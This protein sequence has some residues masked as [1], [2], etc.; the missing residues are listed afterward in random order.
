MAWWWAVASIALV[1]LGTALGLAYILR[2]GNV[3]LVLTYHSLLPFSALTYALLG[4][5]VASRHPGNIIGWLFL[6]TA[7]LLS[8]TALSAGTTAIDSLPAGARLPWYEVVTWTNRW[9]W[10]PAGILPLVFVL[11]FFP[12]GRL[13]SRRWRWLAWATGLA[14]A[15]VVAGVS[16]HPGA[17]AS[18][19]I[20][21]P[22]PYGIPNSGP[23]LEA[24]LNASGA[25]LV[26]SIFGAVW[27]VVLRFRR[28][29]GVERQQIKWV[30]YI[31]A[32]LLAAFSL[33]WWVGP[34]LLSEAA[35]EELGIVMSNLLVLGVAISVS[36]AIL[37]HQLYDIDLVINRT[38]VYGALTAAVVAIYTLVVGGL[39]VAL[40]ARGNVALSW[41]GLALVALIAQPMRD[42]LQRGVN[43][44]M[45]GQ[46]DDPYAVL[47]RLGHQME[48]STAPRDLLSSL[49][50][51]IAETLKLPYVA[52]AVPR[53][54]SAP[55]S[56]SATY[57][58]Y[59]PIAV[60]L[61]L[62]YQS[63]CVGELL[64]A[65]RSSAEP[66]TP[67]EQ[68]L[69]ADIARQAGVVV[70]AAALSSALQQSR[71]H[72]VT[73]REEE[74]RRIRRDLHD[75][76]GPTLASHAYGLDAVLDLI[77]QDPAAAKRLVSDLKSQTQ[78]TLTD[79]RRLVY[80]LRP[81]ALDE[82][83]LVAALQ[84]LLSELGD[85]L[86][87]RVEASPAILPPLSAAVEVAAYRI[88]A[89]AVT[90]AAR[91]AHAQH[92]R[93]RLAASP[94]ELTVDVSDDGRGLPSGPRPGVGLASMR[95]RAAELGGTCT[96]QPNPPGG[97]RVLAHLPLHAPLAAA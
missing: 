58:R 74:R 45:F 68:R 71:E 12:D 61:P 60:R 4:A 67:A 27:A 72:L 83:G 75:G 49:A 62:S 73:T 84:G 93:V 47:S 44:L 88:A 41:L 42:R 87:I 97:T 22:N 76:L 26:A 78:T 23:L 96:I 91:H 3:L 32:V 46:R 80:A 24:V 16:L 65:A 50:E 25:V 15:L 17:I 55:P 14:L 33:A 21:G 10:I 30:A 7:T 70:H 37:R 11:L 89:E 34:P 53:S 38:L 92:C 94:T 63:A 52:I 51:T 85:G 56:I 18:W 19:D 35:A 79:I 95:E 31:A 66:F 13:P 9:A 59:A 20:P 69:L 40:E 86:Q 77:D 36:I 8:L 28:S 2:T 64:V 39:G 81:P 43:R 48:A 1:G 57:G 29:R 54:A 6:A 5:L 82:L 90:N